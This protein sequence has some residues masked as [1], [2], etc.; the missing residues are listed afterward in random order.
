M[1]TRNEVI[2]EF[3]RLSEIIHEKEAEGVI[4]HDEAAAAIDRYRERSDEML[5]PLRPT[6]K[7][8]A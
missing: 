7:V 1:W 6:E 5:R 8:K 2:Q 4:T 3:V